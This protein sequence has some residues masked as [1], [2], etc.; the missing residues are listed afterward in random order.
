MP[1]QFIKLSLSAPLERRLIAITDAGVLGLTVDEV[2]LHFI[3]EALHRDW[4]AQEVQ[5]ERAPAPPPPT[6]ARAIQT[7]AAETPIESPRHIGTRLV[8]MPEVCNRIGIGRSTLYAMIQSG[9]FPAPKR[10]GGRTVAWL[11]S[12]VHAWIESVA[13]GS[14]K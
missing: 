11:E 14:G 3:R 4:L 6:L 5:R 1:S 7:R 8:R 12:E 10:L 2:V 13:S 9:T